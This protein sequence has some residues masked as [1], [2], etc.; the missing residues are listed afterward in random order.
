M[1][2]IKN[3]GKYIFITL[4]IFIAVILIFNYVRAKVQ[5]HQRQEM[6]KQE[7][8]KIESEEEKIEEELVT[9][10]QANRFFQI[11]D[12]EDDYD[13]ENAKYSLEKE[14]LLVSKNPLLFNGHVTDIINSEG[15]Y[16]I[17]FEPT[18]TPEAYVLVEAEINEELFEE[19]TN[20]RPKEV[21]TLVLNVKNVTKA[22]DSQGHDFL[23][24]GVCLDV[25]FTQGT[26]GGI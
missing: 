24:K 7:R 21:F 16:I 19:I 22:R 17:K 1:K 13:Y 18:I 8:W 11:T 14:K 23:I 2:L 5:K 9:K 25:G 10:Y 12:D 4:V 3:T 15:K 26:T 6:L 20:N